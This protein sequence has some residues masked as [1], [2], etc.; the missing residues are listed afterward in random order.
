MNNLIAQNRT[1]LLLLI[2]GLLIALN[3]LLIPLIE[4]QNKLIE[5]NKNLKAQISKMNERIVA[6]PRLQEKNTVTEYLLEESSIHL[7]S[8]QEETSLTQQRELETLF[9]ES[10]LTLRS[11]NWLLNEPLPEGHG[12][13]RAEAN[14]AGSIKDFLNATFRIKTRIPYTKIIDMNLRVSRK[15]QQLTG[16]GL[17]GA[18]I[19][20]IYTIGSESL[21]STQET[22]R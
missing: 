11:F 21:P 16:R 14:V 5:K 4:W 3:F 6:A 10:N 2:T 12:R 7:A 18:I 19:M 20:E 9:K 13:L 8:S 15:E 17:N 22:R 1:K